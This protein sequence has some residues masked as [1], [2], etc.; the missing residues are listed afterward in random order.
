MSQEIGPVTP[1]HAMSLVI[2][3]TT[4]VT[5]TGDLV[6]RSAVKL[7]LKNIRGTSFLL[8]RA[9]YLVFRRIHTS[10][11]NRIN[12][13]ERH[14]SYRNDESYSRNSSTPKR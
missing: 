5:E 13:K 8:R 2:M 12:A 1:C 14:V 7:H 6:F 3:L 11:I 10:E 4:V 9:D